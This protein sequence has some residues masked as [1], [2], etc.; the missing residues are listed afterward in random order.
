MDEILR[1]VGWILIEFS[2]GSVQS[3]HTTLNAKI[4]T[5]YGVSAKEGYLFDVD[6]LKFIRFREDADSVRV[7]KDKPVF[8]SEVLQFASRFI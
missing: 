3:V 5:E 2:D 4:L 8:E 1:N 6:K 7:C